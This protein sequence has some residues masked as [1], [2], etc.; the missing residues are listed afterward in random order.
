MLI[1]PFWQQIYDYFIL[2]KSRLLTKE[3]LC[4]IFN[5]SEYSIN[6]SLKILLENNLVKQK[7]IWYQYIHNHTEILEIY[8]ENVV[9]ELR[10]DKKFPKH[11][12]K[13]VQAIIEKKINKSK[14]DI[15]ELKTKYDEMMKI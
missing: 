9:R 7:G 6:N 14:F 8:I 13:P 10:V 11:N 1:R 2:H 5:K 15:D 12:H 3:D 4:N